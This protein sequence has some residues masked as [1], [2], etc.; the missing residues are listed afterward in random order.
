MPILTNWGKARA[1]ITFQILKI[2]NH[3][4]IENYQQDKKVEIGPIL[5]NFWPNFGRFR[6]RFGQSEISGVFSQNFVPEI[7]KISVGNLSE[8]SGKLRYF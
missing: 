4:K 2:E 7:S 1:K 6:A 5:A 3:T 8:I